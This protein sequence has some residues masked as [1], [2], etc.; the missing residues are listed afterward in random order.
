M[1]MAKLRRGTGTRERERTTVLIIALEYLLGIG[2]ARVRSPLDQGLT[3]CPFTT[4]RPLITPRG[5]RS[6]KKCH[7]GP[8]PA[9]FVIR[10]EPE[11]TIP[12]DAAGEP[13][14]SGVRVTGQLDWRREVTAQHAAADGAICRFCRGLAR[15]TLRA[16]GVFFSCAQ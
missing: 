5:S 1:Q 9:T 10:Q 4:G 11:T 14:S 16:A 8:R 3:S 6:D 12:E 15:L 7:C 2:R 13:P